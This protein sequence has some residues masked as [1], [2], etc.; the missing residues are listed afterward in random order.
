MYRLITKLHDLQEYLEAADTVAF[1]FETAPDETYR[2]EEKAALDPH[3]SRIVGIS[4]SRAEGD[5]VYVP[6][7]HRIGENASNL[8]ALW[9]YLAGFFA[10]TDIIKVAH[11][12]AF[13]SMFLYAKPM[14]LA[15][16]IVIQPPVYDTIAAA[17]MTLKGNTGFRTLADSGLKTLVPALLDKELPTFG[18]VTAGRHFDEL[19]PG[20]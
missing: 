5:A 12:L 18:E 6:L 20:D 9:D 8:T 2:D 11:N 19:D 3:K 16:G 4:F 10:R 17:Q 13:E 1:D 14:G 7:T 15:S